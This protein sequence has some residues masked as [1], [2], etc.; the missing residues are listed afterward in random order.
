VSVNR[1]LIAG[2]ISALAGLPAAQGAPETV[3]YKSP[4]GLLVAFIVPTQASHSTVESSVEVRT[5]EGKLLVREQYL[6]K[7]GEHGFGVV[8][9]T[10]TSDSQFFVFSLESSGGHQPWH[11]PVQYFSR[12]LGK[13]Q[14]LDDALGDAIADPEFKVSAPDK[15]TVELHFSGKSET[16]SLSALPSRH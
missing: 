1:V 11:S 14:S 5:S 15:V 13:I 2:L 3:A 10:W 6:S 7:D 16:V 4:D 8:R 12:S 9:A